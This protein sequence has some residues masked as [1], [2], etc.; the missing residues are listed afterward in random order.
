MCFG[1]SP[2][3]IR[4]ASL[5]SLVTCVCNCAVQRRRRK[6]HFVVQL[7]CNENKHIW[8]R[9]KSS[10]SKMIRIEKRICELQKMSPV[11]IWPGPSDLKNWSQANWWAHATGENERCKK[12]RKEV[13]ATRSIKSEIQWNQIHRQKWKFRAEAIS[14]LQNM[15]PKLTTL[16]VSG[17]N[18]IFTWENIQQ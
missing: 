10:E 16:W 4:Q 15:R 12:K 13:R 8:N 18:E 6:P 5:W 9:F 3:T 7:S 14:P 17:T 2:K 11:F 1:E